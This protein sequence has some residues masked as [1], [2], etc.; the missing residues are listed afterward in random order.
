M[1]TFIHIHKYYRKPNRSWYCADCSHYMVKNWTYKLIGRTSICWNCGKEFN[2]SEANLEYDR[3]I[4]FKCI[5]GM[6]SRQIENF[7]DAL[8]ERMREVIEKKRQEEWE[9][10]KKELNETN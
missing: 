1:T 2:M 6:K 4:C 3:P 8:E 7:G 9:N 5:A 10:R